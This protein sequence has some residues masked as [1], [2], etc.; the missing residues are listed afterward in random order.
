MFIASGVV[1]NSLTVRLAL[2]LPLTCFLPE[3][4]ADLEKTEM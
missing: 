4:N 3:N 2:F 1:V